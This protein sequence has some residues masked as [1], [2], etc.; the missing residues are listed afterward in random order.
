MVVQTM[1]VTRC[2]RACWDPTSG[3]CE[4]KAGLSYTLRPCLKTHIVTV[5]MTHVMF[6]PEQW[7]SVW[8][9]EWNVTKR[10]KVLFCSCCCLR[11]KKTDRNLKIQIFKPNL[12]SEKSSSDHVTAVDLW[13]WLWFLPSKQ[14]TLVCLIVFVFS[15]AGMFNSPA[16]HWDGPIKFYDNYFLSEISIQFVCETFR[17]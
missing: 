6:T 4:A 16:D 1:N 7:K 10:S 17:K 5:M 9:D 12:T 15:P 3:G 2:A 14:R 13:I 11:R 8:K